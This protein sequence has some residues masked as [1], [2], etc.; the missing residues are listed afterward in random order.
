MMIMASEYLV[1][2]MIISVPGDQDDDDDFINSDDDNDGPQAA[3]CKYELISV[4]GDHA[5]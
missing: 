1:I 5:I 3:S 4:P 2:K